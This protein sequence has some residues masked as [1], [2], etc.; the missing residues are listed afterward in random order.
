MAPGLAR[1]HPDIGTYY[2]RGIDDSSASIAA[3]LSHIG[4]HAAVRSAHGGWYIDPYFRNN[5]SRY[6]SYSG[7]DLGHSFEFV[8]HGVVKS[9]EKI[10]KT[11]GLA[12]LAPT[13]DVLR[14]YRLALITDPG[15]AAYVGGPANV[16]AAKVALINRVEPGLPRRHVDP[17][18]LIANNDLLN[19]NDWAAG[20]RRR[21]APAAPP[22]ASRSRKSRAARAVARNR[23]VDRPDRRRRR[24]STS[25]TSPSAQ[26]G[27]G[28]ANLGVVGRA[29][30]AQGCTGIP[31]PV[32][33]FYAIDYVAHEMGHQFSGNHPFNGNQLNCSGGQPQRGAPRSSRA[34][35]PRSWRTRASA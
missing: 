20:D 32:G 14:T 19:L 17:L 31:T 21:T 11:A 27:G 16:T 4:F 7:T 10:A 2:G 25:A 23:F 13:G 8:E 24:T 33:D 9:D 34:P 29:N 22:P 6:V 12:A 15:Y 26:P 3:D 30:K 1:K 5:T 35:A 28:V 18:Q